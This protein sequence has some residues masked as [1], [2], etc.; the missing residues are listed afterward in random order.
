MRPTLE[1]GFI[2]STSGTY[3]RMAEHG[4]AGARHALAEVNAQA[5]YPFELKATHFN[6]EGR[7]HRYQEGALAMMN[8]GIRHLFGTTTSASRKEIIPDLEQ[9]ASLLW[10]SCPY[11][12]FESCENVVYLGGCPNQTLLPLLRYAINTF[13]SRAM[14]LGSNYI[15]GWESNRIA[16]EVLQAAHGE[17][18][19]EKYMHLGATQFAELAQGLIDQRPS[20]IL[21]N[22]VGESSYAFLH[23]LNT[24]CAQARISLAVLSCNLTEAELGDVGT[25]EHLRLLSCGPFFDGVNAAFTDGQF[26]R[27]G[28]QRCSHY[29]TGTYVAVHL[30]AQALRHTGSD[31]PAA[32]CHYLQEHTQ[33]SVLGDL[34]ISARNN[35]SSLPCHIAELKNGRFE[36]LY[37]EAQALL[38]DPYLTATDFREFHHLRA[39]APAPRLRIVT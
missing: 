16:R 24:A 23:Q 6:P 13:G 27:H 9:N 8:S 36:V 10:Y 38:P 37:S 1:L 5:G 7:L 18:L 34:T 2:F 25:L 35:H 11:E 17:V 21:N 4:L 19:G 28:Q 15:W 30:F 32:I 29:Y 20:F 22:L 3:R 31:A 33:G 26:E 14:L 39:A 12:G